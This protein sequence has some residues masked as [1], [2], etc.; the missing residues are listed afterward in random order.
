MDACYCDYGEGP[1]VIDQKTVKAKKAH[2][3]SECRGAILPGE[4]YRKTW[5]IWEGDAHT[6]KRCVDC[7]T[8]VAW[9][10][11]HIKCICFYYGDELSNIL[12][13]MAEYDAEC[14]GLL[15]EAEDKIKAVRTKRREL[16]NSVRVRPETPD[17]PAQDA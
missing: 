17:A 5:G 8:L 12:E 6:Y 4:L 2:K 13:A 10:E 3:C 16:Y 7:G 11:A 15:G 14:P 1:S 9:A